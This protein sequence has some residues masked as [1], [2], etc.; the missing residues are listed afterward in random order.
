ML[1]V[2]NISFSY[3]P[4]RALEEVSL[5]L[6]QGELVCLLGANG[7][8]KTTLLSLLSG[9]IKPKQ[10][11]VTYQGEVL[12]GRKPSQ[13]VRA[14]L[15][16]VPEGRQLFGPLTVKENLELGAF[17]RRDDP[18]ALERDMTRVMDIFP[19][20]A[21]RR[22]QLAGTLSGGEQQM[23]AIGRG[24]MA[25]PKVLLLDEP[26]LGLAPLIT[27]EI[28]QIIKEL[29]AKGTS[30]LVVEQNALAALSVCQRGYVLTNGRIR[31]SGSS[32]DIFQ[33]ELLREAF[34]GPERKN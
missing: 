22:H 11:R 13:V 9:L 28:F 30:V 5:E 14:G 6:A 29:P 27:R 31:A 26:S 23:V 20:L 34:L 32:Q 21:E 3:G 2:E 19:I 24:L 8:G 7:A 4:V 25:S 12:S 10:G 18:K 16:H 33:D 1:K 17:T 15:V